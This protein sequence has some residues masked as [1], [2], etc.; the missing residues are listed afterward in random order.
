MPPSRR[1]S[2]MS[3]SR[4]CGRAVAEALIALGGN[5]GDARATLHKAVDLF[6]DGPDV[7]LLARSADYR[8]PPWGDETQAPFTTLCIAVETGLTPQALLTRA[9]Q[10]ER[11]LGRVRARG[12]RGGPRTADLDILAYDD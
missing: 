7:R 1:S 10:A 2:P 4:W 3:A 6:C 11:V 12:R 9:Q 5:V 8:P